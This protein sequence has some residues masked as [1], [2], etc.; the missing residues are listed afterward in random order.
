MPYNVCARV[1]CVVCVVC[2]CCVTPTRSPCLAAATGLRNIC[3]DFTCRD[4]RGETRDGHAVQR[5]DRSLGE[6]GRGPWAVC[7][8]WSHLALQI[9]C[10]HLE[11]ETGAT[12]RQHCIASVETADAC[13]D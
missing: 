7:E 4:E 10:G 8:D 6:G 11:H 5:R 12:A 2:V 3:S 9:E 13:I 1:V